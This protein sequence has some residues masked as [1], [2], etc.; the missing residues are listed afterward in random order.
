MR[1]ICG[2]DPGVGGAIGFLNEDGTYAGVEDMPTC[3]STTGRREI[4]AADLA[5]ILRSYAP[6]FCLV[7]RVGA[8]PGEGAVGAFSFGRS[9]GCIL[10]VL[11]ALQIPHGTVQPAVW[12]RKADIPPGA[13]KPASIGAAKRLIPTATENL[14]L[15]KHDGRAEALLLARHALKKD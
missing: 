3:T 7:E 13:D 9:F 12:K 2:I 10:G 8:R 11:A 14:N 4:D 15:K 6:T 5:A 1:L